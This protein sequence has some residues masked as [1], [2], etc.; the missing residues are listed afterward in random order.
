MDALQPTLSKYTIYSDSKVKQIVI[1]FHLLLLTNS[2]PYRV[3]LVIL[4]HTVLSKPMLEKT[5]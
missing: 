2:E 3:Q 4:S 5:L 1:T